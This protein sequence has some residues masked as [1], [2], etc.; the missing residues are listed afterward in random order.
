MRHRFWKVDPRREEYGQFP[1]ITII[2]SFFKTNQRFSDALY[3]NLSASPNISKYFLLLPKD[4]YHLTLINLHVADSFENNTAWNRFLEKNKRFFNNLISELSRK[5]IEPQIKI[6]GLYAGDVLQI[7]MSLDEQQSR[8]LR[9]LA[10]KNGITNKIPPF[11]HITL[12]YS[13]KEIPDS[14]KP[15]IN[16]ELSRAVISALPEVILPEVIKFRPLAPA[17]LCSFASMTHFSPVWDIS[18]AMIDDTISPTS[19]RRILF[20]NQ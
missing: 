16:E 15:K 7:G 14:I 8:K 19:A 20:N 12:A 5:K 10:H 13:Y 2:S 9:D 6:D 17:Q 3:K 18:Q 4:S 11:F 1:G